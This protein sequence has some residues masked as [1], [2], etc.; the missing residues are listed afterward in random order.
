M[1]NN[2]DMEILRMLADRIFIKQPLLDDCLL[3]SIQ[4][5]PVNRSEFISALIMTSK[6]L[7]ENAVDSRT[8]SGVFYP[9]A[10]YQEL[11]Q[12]PYVKYFTEYDGKFVM[13]NEDRIRQI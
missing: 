1:N 4:S 7:K 10:L 13:M 6:A 11:A 9:E 5:L 2:V 8:L 3:R 12:D